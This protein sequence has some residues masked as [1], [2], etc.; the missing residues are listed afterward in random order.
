MNYRR[1]ALILVG[2]VAASCG[3]L[4]IADSLYADALPGVPATA[5]ELELV[6][7]QGCGEAC[8]TGSACASGVPPT[9]ITSGSPPDVG[10]ANL[11]DPCNTC[12]GAANVTCDGSGVV[13][14]WCQETTAQCCTPTKSCRLQ[15]GGCACN[16]QDADHGMG[17]VFSCTTTAN[18]PR[19]TGT[20][21]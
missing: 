7:A 12:T 13:T 17:L 4:W 14:T 8:V 18:D 6:R 3:L 16:L 1:L 20:G 2:T 15:S 9:C 11:G 21:S 10:C 5:E 19:C